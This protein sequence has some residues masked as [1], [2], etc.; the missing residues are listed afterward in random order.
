MVGI[1]IMIIMLK[2]MVKRHFYQYPFL[3]L[4]VNLTNF[5]K[6][7]ICAGQSRGDC[8]RCVSNKLYIVQVLVQ[9][10][11]IDEINTLQFPC[12]AESETLSNNMMVMVIAD[13]E[14]SDID[15]NCDLCLV[16]N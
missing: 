5:P 2:M 9:N 13:N 7:P 11:T 15:V 4:S 8:G 3:A 14:D 6:Q 12:K 10:C 16:E 1:I